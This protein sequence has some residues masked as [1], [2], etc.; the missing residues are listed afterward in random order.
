[1]QSYSIILMYALLFGALWFFMIRP[2]KK[3]QQDLAKMRNDLVVGDSV[4]TIG[5]IVGRVS[6]IKEDEIHLN[7]GHNQE[8]LVVKKWAIGTVQK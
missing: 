8:I 7:V 1:M 5:G 4:T 6:V 3:K 2:Q